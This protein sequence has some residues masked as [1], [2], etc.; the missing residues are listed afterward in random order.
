MGNLVVRGLGAPGQQRED[1]LRRARCRFTPIG[2]TPA[3]RLLWLVIRKTTI[4]SPPSSRSHPW[5]PLLAQPEADDHLGSDLRA[6]LAGVAI[7]SGMRRPL[8]AS[9]H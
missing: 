3:S 1:L 4:G 8:G 2:A 6:H 9:D 7:E 5:R